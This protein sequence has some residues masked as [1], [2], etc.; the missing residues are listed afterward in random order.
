MANDSIKLKCGKK[1]PFPSL[2]TELRFKTEAEMLR[3]MEVRYSQSQTQNGIDQ[4]DGIIAS[5]K[6]W[7]DISKYIF[8]QE[9]YLS[10]VPKYKLTDR[11]IIID[12]SLYLLFSAAD[13]D[14]LSLINTLTTSDE[15]YAVVKNISENQ[16][17]RKKIDQNIELL[18]PLL[19]TR[20]IRNLLEA[21]IKNRGDIIV[22]PS[23]PITSLFRIKE[24]IKKCREMNRISRILFDTVFSGVKDEKDLMNVLSIRLSTIQPEYTD[25][26]KDILLAN[27]P[28][29]IGIRIMGLDA[30]NTSQ[31]W[32]LLTFLKDLSKENK[33]IY[34]FNVRE[35]GYVTLCYGVNATSTPIS[36]DPYFVRSISDKP[37]PRRGS[38]YHPMDMTND[39]YNRLLEKTRSNKYLLPCHCEICSR[40]NKILQIKESE[41]NEF[42]RIHFILVKNMEIK[43]LREVKVPL[44]T[45]L[46]DK[47]ARSEQTQWLPYLD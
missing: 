41:W 11:V 1:L 7:P 47:F 13:F 34:V 46:R 5:I 23:I 32:S 33:P 25:S 42:R 31:I 26:L 28:D 38:Y 15:M 4:L 18:Y 35:F 8:R 36:A 43:E 21:Q 45:A 22:S 24:Q 9:S 29:Q 2:F 17:P 16:S 39:T 37:I 20:I 3:E 19:D 10:P 27:N 40:Y 44:M 14:K 30:E 12:P 6:D